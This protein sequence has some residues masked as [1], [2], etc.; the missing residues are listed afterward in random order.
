MEEKDQQTASTSKLTDIEQRFFNYF[1]NFIFGSLK[2]YFIY[3][4]IKL[5]NQ[6][7]KGISDK[8]IQKELPELTPIVRAS[9]INKL[10]SKVCIYILFFQQNNSFLI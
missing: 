9:I 5:A 8:E 1:F 4:I 2:F 10:L 7:D 3:R 6:N